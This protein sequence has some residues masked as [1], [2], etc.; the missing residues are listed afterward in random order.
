MLS[1]DLVNDSLLVKIMLSLP[2]AAVSSCWLELAV[3]HD[4][5]LHLEIVAGFLHS[6]SSCLPGPP[7]LPTQ[8]PKVWEESL[9]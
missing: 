8:E 7:Q 3:P 2:L 4:G 5:V 6:P 1:P 9:D